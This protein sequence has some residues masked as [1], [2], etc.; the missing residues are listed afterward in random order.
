MRSYH[1]ELGLVQLE[2]KSVNIVAFGRKLFENAIEYSV[3]WENRKQIWRLY[4][5][6]EH[7]YSKVSSNFRTVFN[8]SLEMYF[9]V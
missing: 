7:T 6:Y 5:D 9:F 2:G 1:A 4:F 8:H 3:N